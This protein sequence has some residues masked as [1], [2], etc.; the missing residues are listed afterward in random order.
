M[1]T[2]TEIRKQWANPGDVLSLLLLIGG[3]IVQKAIAQLV[4]YQLHLPSQRSR[5]FAVTPVVFSFGWAAY[6]FANLLSAFGD[7]RLMP[8]NDY[9]SILV[10]SSNGF[11]RDTRS[12]VLGRLLR[13]HEIRCDCE[14][15]KSRTEGAARH[16]VRV[17]IFNVAHM[18]SPAL[19]LLW[20]SGWM[21][22][23]L[24]LAIATVPWVLYNDWAIVMVTL[25]GNLLA[26]IT[27]S[28]PQW[29][30]EK[31]AAAT[32]K[33]EKVTCLTRGNGHPYI[34]VCIGA[35]GSWDFESLATGYTAPQPETRSISLITA[36]L[37]TCLLITVAGIQEHTWFLVGIGGL[38]M[39]QNTFA[40]G[41]SREPASSGFRVT[42]FS[43]ASTIIGRPQ[44]ENDDPD[45]HV[46]LHKDS[47]QLS[48]LAQ[49]ASQ[50]YLPPSQRTNTGSSGILEM[51]KWLTSMKKEDGVPAWLE[52]LKAERVPTAPKHTRSDIFPLGLY[53]RLF[54]PTS[55]F[56]EVIY[57]SGVHGALMELEK[58]VPTA[59]LTMARIFFPGGLEYNDSSVRDNIHKKFWRRAYHTVEVRKKA[60]VKR[61]QAELQ[62]SQASV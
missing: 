30:Q 8:V 27:C 20:W 53:T 23:V 52:P 43:R 45:A 48:D 57:A 19:D 62:H 25:C 33:K 13:D 51:P 35:P 50:P 44:P 60:E 38:G 9:P 22:L 36:A 4:G 11:V 59:G 61:R 54:T 26:A 40:A 58:W 49:W 5:R 55:S 2:S 24:Q 7:M 16:S 17:D 21:I 10:N 28:I 39:L 42:P 37:W 46:D 18:P 15:A 3:D 29:R 41:S 34:M 6:A 14:A 12:W 1:S 47:E 32:L 56:Q 31:W